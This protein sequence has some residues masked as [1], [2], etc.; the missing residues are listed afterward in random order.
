MFA[1][2]VQRIAPKFDRLRR[3]IRE[4]GDRGAAA[5]REDPD[6]L[7]PERALVFEVAG[8]L[9]DFYAQT[10]RIPGLEFLAEDEV[11]FSPD[12]DFAVSEKRDDE[13]VRT[14]DL[15]PGRLYLAMPDLLALRQILSLWD[16]YARGEQLPTGFAPWRSLFELLR[17]VRVWGPRD[18]VTADTV[19][20]WRERITQNPDSP[21]RFEVELWFHESPTRRRTA[22]RVLGQ[23]LAKLGG[24]II[25]EVAIPPIRYHGVLVDLPP[26][27]I[28][29]L[30]ANPTVT[31]AGFEDIMFIRPQSLASFPVLEE[32]DAIELAE[33]NLGRD[34]GPPD[35]EP[36]VAL[37]DGVPL[38]NHRRLVGRIMLDDPDDL[39]A[40]SPVQNREHGTSMAS[41]IIHG[42]LQSGEEPLAAP[43]YVRP[44]MVFDA[45]TQVETTPTDRLPLDLIY[46][47][48][49]RMKEGDANTASVAP[50]VVVINLSLGDGNRPFTGRISPWARMLDWLAFRYR[51]LFL[52]SVGNVGRWLPVAEYSTR[53]EFLD[54]DPLQRENK[55]LAAMDSEKA[56]RTIL[57]P[58]EGINALAV[59][60]WHADSSAIP[61]GAPHV[62]DPFPNGALPNVSSALGL[63]HRRT[64]KPDLMFDGGRELV[65]LS[66]DEGL[67]WLA[68]A[69]AA[70]YVG[71]LAAAP[72]SSATGRLNVER[73]TVGSSNATALL[74]RAAAQVLRSLEEAGEAIP[75]EYQAVVLKALLVHGAGWGDTGRRLEELWGPFGRAHMAGRDNIARFLGY[76]RPD[77][78]RVLDCT[79]E[80]ATLLGFGD[81]LQ[82]REDVFRIPLPPSL[83][84]AT[85]LRRLTITLA[86]LAPVNARHQSYRAA[87]LEVLPGG[88]RKFSLAVNRAGSQPNHKAVNRGTVC[89]TIYEGAKAIAFL[90]DG[91]LLLRVTCRTP[92]GTVDD[93]IP[94]GLA[95]S[96]ETGIG[97]RISVYDEVR[98]A[99]Q[100]R[101]RAGVRT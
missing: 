81:L 91:N 12:D 61:L 70:N 85:E 74:S 56:W 59:G 16:R 1:R 57:S 52:V 8:S 47:A 34:D 9:L 68:P 24:G 11:E 97:S 92:A 31:V 93:P 67:V 62:V 89:H 27:Q 87:A 64:I 25:A 30:I 14:D 83:E 45:S 49:R 5:L 28:R 2:Q 78:Q 100:P 94:Y 82:E 18:R 90:D 33:D 48:V 66:E 71:Q 32:P 42:D 38:A 76:G 58:A 3:V 73:R 21:V 15:V 99:I 50:S 44:V 72:D 39:A 35:A 10:Q 86:W 55:I 69:K 41:L 63:G 95:I 77:I 40:L 19:E 51:V 36:V 54:A 46:Q 17:E 22:I 75:R 37:F 6:G 26:G 43:V 98:L 4:L 96:V 53:R 13:V 101:V 7:A 23:Q 84:G 20:Y 79:A 88:D 80:R 65:M 60:A 29:E